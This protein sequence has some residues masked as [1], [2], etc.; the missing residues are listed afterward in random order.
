MTGHIRK[1]G[2]HSWQ[3]FLELPRT[4][5]GRRRQKTVTVRGTKR[6][7]EAELTRMTNEIATGAFVEP[8]R[9]TV[10]AFL[11][12]W[13]ADSAAI[14]VSAKTLERYEEIVRKHLIAALG[15][16]RLVDLRPLHIQEYYAAALRSG[17]LDGK[18]A[19]SAQT[20]LH[21]H[22]VLREAL[23]QAVRWQLLARNPADAVDPPKP[24]RRE[25]QV[26]D[27]TET[28]EVLAAIRDSR[29][30]L[31][32]FVAVT[33]GLRR[34]E[35]LALQWNDI[36]LAEQRIH[37]N[38]TVEQTKHHVRVKEPKTAKG[39]RTV[40]I[41]PVLVKELKRYRAAQLKLRLQVGAEFN[42]DGLLFYNERG[43][44]W[45][46][47]AL[48]RAFSRVMIR[49]G[50]KYVRLHDLRHS[51]ATQLLRHDIHPK[52]VQERLGHS[53]FKL[54]MDTYTHVIPS[55]QEHAADEV[56]AALTAALER[57]KRRPRRR[58][59]R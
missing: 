27:E 34:G 17:R 23:H 21:H 25:M 39:R 18:G 13:L 7:A 37:V 57:V 40:T 5:D 48:T 20:V 49:L 32:V 43:T 58:A 6:Q 15:P 8:T 12:R 38:R 50:G 59:P 47:S 53:S 26:L 45:R 3:I 42:K 16:I 46:P 56:D 54:T 1:R 2:K 22:R 44:L 35:V 24:S 14:R 29:L 10:S 9:M 31:A 33:T 4:R 30:R 11:D 19:L 51:H 41:P 52:I 36:D 55:L 28:A